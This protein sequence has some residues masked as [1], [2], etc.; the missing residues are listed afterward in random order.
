METKTEETKKKRGRPKKSDEQ[1]SKKVSKD[2]KNV[3][4]EQENL[5][6][7]KGFGINGNLI[8]LEQRTSSELARMRSNG[9]K[10][11]GESRRRK[12][13]L[14]EFTRDFL[15]QEAVPALKGNMNMLGVEAEQMTNL[16]ALI[17]RLFSKAVNQ[18]DLNAA[19]TIIEWAGM[20]PLQEVRENEAIAR[21]GQAMQLASG[22]G[23]SNED[24]MDVVFYIP[25][26]NRPVLS[27]EDLVTVGESE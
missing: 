18:G 19:R 1:E 8:A 7:G 10:K 11:S 25:S 21:L 16:G 17:T 14:R 20:A 26:N 15:M 22:D 13:E 24:D 27:G 12:K 4:S 23:S 9:G 2:A 3:A 5:P 6:D